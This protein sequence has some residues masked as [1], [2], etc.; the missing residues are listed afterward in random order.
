MDKNKIIAAF[1]LIFLFNQ[2]SF[3]A[4]LSKKTL[5]NDITYYRKVSNNQNLNINDRYYI[6]LRIEQKYKDSGIDLAPLQM[7]MKKLKT[8]PAAPVPA[9]VQYGTV[10]KI[11]I[12]E[13]DE[14]SKITITTKGSKRSN[15]FLLRDPDPKKSPKI[16]LD[17]YDV[18]ENLT[19]AAKD[20]KT[21][22]GVFSRVTAEQFDQD[23]DK[24]VRIVAEMREEKPYKINKENDL[25]IITAE[26]KKITKSKK[27]EPEV[28]QPKPIPQPQ[29]ASPSGSVDKPLPKKDSISESYNIEMGD[30]LNIDVYPAEELSR[31]VIVQPDGNISVPLIG[32]TK[33]R[34]LTPEKL[35]DVLAKDLSKYITNPKV[36]VSVKKFS[37][38]Q[39]FITG[40]VRGVG[41][42]DYK[43][44]LRLMEFISSLG[45][46]TK[47]AD[48]RQIKVYRGPVTN[49]QTHF[50][51]VEQIIK[52]GDFSKDFLL[53]P[54]DIIEVPKGGSKVV[55]LGDVTYPGY[56]NY[57]DNMNITDLIS[58]AGG[59]KDSAKIQKINILRNDEKDENK[60][61]VIKVDLKKILTGQA[62]DVPLK[63]GDTVYVPK[64]SL[65]R[66]NWFLTYVMPW[67]SLGLLI[68]TISGGI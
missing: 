46:F 58:L 28:T 37:R 10:E 55:I 29:A 56:H 44:D 62:K 19:N 15:Y 6:L 13:T 57:N 39:I 35:Q 63:S 43:E 30:V 60:R 11:L 40:E 17:L 61:Q 66:A 20:I 16:I 53:E 8:A 23:P 33:A 51:D 59:F 24:I 38:R 14:I 9:K 32:I 67:V 31:E 68:A 47:D 41:A 18:N 2:T 48:R 3:A 25:W 49:R 4:P 21:K 26:K 42:Y 45:G 34:G 22:K 12:E 52:T 50:V 1:F 27:S 36:T 5:E 64:K 65:A 54:G 7:E